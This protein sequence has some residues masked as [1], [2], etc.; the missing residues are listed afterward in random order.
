MDTA[1][2]SATARLYCFIRHG[3]WCRYGDVSFWAWLVVSI[4]LWVEVCLVLA[5][6]CYR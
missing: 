2:P 1:K 3:L 5:W 4:L 6:W